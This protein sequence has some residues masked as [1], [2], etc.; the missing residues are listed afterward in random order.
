MPLTYT[1]VMAAALLPFLNAAGSVL[2]GAGQLAGGLGLG[3]PSGHKRLSQQVG[4]E[5][6]HQ[7]RDPLGAAVTSARRHGIHPLYALGA[8]GGGSS[9]SIPG[10][11]STRD[12]ASMGAGT[13]AITDATVDLLRSQKKQTDVET[14]K[15]A[16]EIQQAKNRI[17]NDRAAEAI[18]TALGPPPKKTHWTPIGPLPTQGGWTDAEDVERTHG[19]LAGE[20][21]GGARTISELRRFLNK[22][23]LRWRT[24]PGVRR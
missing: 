3:Q 7:M 17:L 15:T 19:G 23:P 8:A 11:P 20:L 16:D 22:W 18:V 12:Y 6:L 24:W 1:M 5:Q 13:Q 9:V 2:A 14:Q 4:Y 10:R 21:Y